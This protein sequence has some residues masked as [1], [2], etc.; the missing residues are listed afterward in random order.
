MVI[1]R[2]VV[3]ELTRRRKEE[4]NRYDDIVMMIRQHDN[5]N[6]KQTNKPSISRTSTAES[7][8]AVVNKQ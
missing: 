2:G 5:K 7:K 6:N 3:L 1:V 4:R 8:Q